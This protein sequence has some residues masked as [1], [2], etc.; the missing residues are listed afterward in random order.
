MVARNPGRYLAPV[1][2]VAAV[3]ATVLVI[4]AHAGQSHHAAPATRAQTLPVVHRVDSEKAFYVIRAGDSL[5]IISVRTGVSIATLESL[6][7]SVNPD[8]LQT[9]QR[10]RLRP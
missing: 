7:P 6:N 5:S 2:L 3:V 10:L 8:A 4:R 9:G 1:A